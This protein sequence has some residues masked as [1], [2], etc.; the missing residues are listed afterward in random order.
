M[1][2]HS[3][4]KVLI[5][6]NPKSGKYREEVFQKRLADILST[7]GLS[8]E[9]YCFA[10]QEDLAKR[11]T[12]A[13]SE[14]VDA[15][16]VVGGDGTVAMVASH[17]RRKP[18]PI[19]IIP[20]GT[21]NLL[22]QVLGIPIDIKDALNLLASP[23]ETKTIDGLEINGRLFFMNA[24]IGLSSSS[25]KEVK[26]ERKSSLGIFAYVLAV[27]RRVAKATSHRFSLEIDGK[28]QQVEAAEIFIANIGAVGMPKYR[29]ADSQFDD[30]KLEVCVIYK[31]TPR[32]LL[33][34]LL[35]LLVR[36]R[37]RSIHRIAR[38]ERITI[39]CEEHLPVQA[40]GDVVEETP[41]TIEVV[42]RAATF[43]VPRS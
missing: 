22:A 2:Q 41:V 1:G 20:A 18:A 10:G 24:S 13:R 4:K 28:L 35:D 23:T 32:E 31:N 5:V 42:P 9:L 40:D 3:N 12:K 11:L 33:N 29:L 25:V 36:K 19:F 7:Q 8:G 30:G 15:F 16:V 38:G 34:A 14:P 21:T 27:I 37:K 39:S 17:L 26:Q 43:V 6:A